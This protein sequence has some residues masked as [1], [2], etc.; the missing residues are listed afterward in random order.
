MDFEM[1]RCLMSELL[2]HATQVGCM[3]CGVYAPSEKRMARVRLDGY[4]Q[5]G[6]VRAQHRSSSTVY[7]QILH[8]NCGLTAAADD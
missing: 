6:A 5:G 4:K 1:V 2:R 7:K 8:R 3:T